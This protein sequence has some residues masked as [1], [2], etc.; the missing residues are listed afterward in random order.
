MPHHASSHGASSHTSHPSQKYASCFE[1]RRMPVVSPH[2]RHIGR[3]F[4]SGPSCCSAIIF[5]AAGESSTSRTAPCTNHSPRARRRFGHSAKPIDD[6]A[7]T[8]RA[9]LCR[10]KDRAVSRDEECESRILLVETEF[11]IHATTRATKPFLPSPAPHRVPGLAPV[12]GNHSHVQTLPAVHTR[13]FGLIAK[14]VGAHDAPSR[15]ATGSS[16]KSLMRTPTCVIVDPSSK[17]VIFM[18]G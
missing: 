13:S 10:R 16:I 9:S 3:L 4:G 18:Y 2:S 7:A 14:N 12:T 17:Y 6:R 15:R 8:L 11:L 5:D 1:S